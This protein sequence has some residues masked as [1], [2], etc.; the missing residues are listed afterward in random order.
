MRLKSTRQQVITHTAPLIP[1]A[2]AYARGL[3][4]GLRAPNVIE[5]C[6]TAHLVETAPAV[7]LT[8]AGS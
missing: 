1:Q 5:Q 8:C 7:M 4:G 6:I 3:Y 2:C